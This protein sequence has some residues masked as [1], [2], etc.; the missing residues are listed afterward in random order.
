M[1][2]K[3]YSK[4]LMLSALGALGVCGLFGLSVQK[5]ANSVTRVNAENDD[6]SVIKTSAVNFCFN[7]KGW[8]WSTFQF[9]DGDFGSTQDNKSIAS[10]YNSK[11]NYFEKVYVNNNPSLKYFT[12]TP[13]AAVISIEGNE[14]CISF[15][16]GCCLGADGI[17]SVTIP[18]GTTFPSLGG[19]NG[20]AKTYI[21]VTE[22]ITFINQA[23]TGTEWK[24]AFVKSGNKD[25]TQYSSN[26]VNNVWFPY[27]FNDFDYSVVNI[28]STDCQNALYFADQLNMYRNIKLR[29]IGT[30]TF[31]PLIDFVMPNSM[32]PGFNGNVHVNAMAFTALSE[33][34]KAIVNR[35][36]PGWAGVNTYWEPDFAEMIIPA[37][38]QFPCPSFYTGSYEF[39][40]TT[41]DR[42]FFNK[43]NALLEAV[44]TPKKV[45]M[46]DTSLINA[47]WLPLTFEGVNN[48]THGHVIWNDLDR[49]LL[50][51]DDILIKIKGET[52]FK[53]IGT[54]LS[55]TTTMGGFSG[56]SSILGFAFDTVCDGK[57]TASDINELIIP[58]GTRFPAPSFASD[59]ALFETTN[60]IHA[61]EFGNHLFS[62]NIIED[63][64]FIKS[65]VNGWFAF[66]FGSNHNADAPDGFNDNFGK[67]E[68]FN[69]FENIELTS[70]SDETFHLSDFVNYKNSAGYRRLFE[71]NGT[72]TLEF[73]PNTE[74]GINSLSDFKRI[75]VPR[76]TLFPTYNYGSE[77]I[78]I[79]IDKDYVF[80]NANSTGS[81]FYINSVEN[82][83]PTTITYVGGY[84][85]FVE[86]GTNKTNFI[87]NIS[88]SLF[89]VDLYP[90]IPNVT[91]DAVI[92]F[93][94]NIEFY[95]AEDKKI[96]IDV[97]NHS[98]L[99]E[100]F[101]ATNTDYLIQ[102]KDNTVDSLDKVV[103]KAGMIL[104]TPNL[105]INYKLLN[106]QVFYLHNGKLVEKTTVKF[107]D[108]E[109]VEWYKG[110]AL[111]TLPAVPAHEA[112]AEGKITYTGYWEDASGNR[113]SSSTVVN[114]AM[115]LS[116]GY[117][118]SDTIYSV[119]FMDG[120]TELTDLAMSKAWNATEIDLPAVPEKTGYTGKWVSEDVTITKGKFDMAIKNV[121]IKT[122]YTANK[123][124]LSFGAGVDPIQV[125]YDSKIGT[126]PD[127]PAKTG[128]HDG[129][130]K[131]GDTTIDADT[132]W[133]FVEN[134]QATASYTIDE[135][136]VT[137]D[138][139]GGSTV[140]SQTVEFN[141][142]AT[143][144][145]DPTKENA[146]F[147]GWFADQTL[148]TA[149]DFNAGI[150]GNTTIY[151]KFTNCAP[152]QATYSEPTED[153]NMTGAIKCSV[154]GETL[155]E[156]TVQG[157]FVTDTPA[158][159][160]ATGVGHWVYDFSEEGLT[161]QTISNIVIPVIG[162]EMTKHDAV[163]AT[164]DTA[165]RLEYWTCAHEEGVYFK[166]EAGT[167]TFENLEATVVPA[168]GHNMS[169]HDAVA[170]TCE[171]AGSLEY[172]TC[173]NEPGVYYKD[174]TRTETFASFEATIVAALGHQMTKHNAVDA[175]CET[176]G[177]VDYWTCAR[178]DG[179]YFKNEAGT[180]R[181]ANLEATIV[182]ALGHDYR[183][184][185]EVAA[186]VEKEGTLAHYVCD[187]CGKI[188]VK[189]GENYIEKTEADLVIAKLTPTEP[190]QTTEKPKAG[191]FGSVAATSALVTS[192]A[193][194]AT[195][196]LVSKKRKE[197]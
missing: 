150:T 111:G 87:F 115:V 94:N 146:H 179:V 163:E 85:S 68:T 183:F 190:E 107:G 19:I 39:V 5:E 24:K 91:T 3:V 128:Y 138:V 31:R 52:D 137:F 110:D 11:L 170:P 159:C 42:V 116:A 13:D 145:A 97:T 78:A 112:D 173:S 143:K 20:T 1:K 168:L 15:S 41:K 130:W 27:S 164:C 28:S 129:V 184:V 61:Y 186:T 67:F 69:L 162:H 57:I 90:N 77:H 124:E 54:L 18:K 175:T 86:S 83:I 99:Y 127:V 12:S 147:G 193:L 33:A 102:F 7:Y 64:L 119:K 167:E 38:T 6:Y 43:N 109:A 152:S 185:P 10:N 37:G 135:Y 142:K 153:H 22:E 172:W 66:D 148:Q 151:A 122:E 144:P 188:F 96:Q 59:F 139:N 25:F 141:A 82:L 93:Y 154:G 191:C 71:N 192:F 95:D 46:V 36:N 118:E 40:E 4:L 89:T 44:I 79:A 32:Q 180:E 63:S 160:T 182:S 195:G 156:E 140:E 50:N 149:F 169:K 166:N 65:G 14:N 177:N 47:A 35:S 29:L 171:T 23:V 49:H 75:F 123:Y 104:P 132:V 26:L 16:T 60:E 196:L 76:G 81:Y 157:T 126:L 73:V 161:D 125:T 45:E 187:E 113:V 106:D 74:K 189:E 84:Q 136:T 134:K 120:E 72:F 178:E 53:K 2:K 48:Y 21:E 108:N 133:N 158:T 34:D 17:K 121:V 103:F 62:R 176:A 117:D 80:E 8:K 56:N 55:K 100:N 92:S 165:G 58:A 114:E 105:T 98:V 181:F 131:I 197:D 174:E 88:N 70:K 101:T 51:Y 194:V 30:D 155:V 9:N